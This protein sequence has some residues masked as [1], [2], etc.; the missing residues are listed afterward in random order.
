LYGLALE[1]L[2]LLARAQTR[3]LQSG[4][5]R[6]Y[7]MVTIATTVGLVGYTLAGSGQLNHVARKPSDAKFY[8][9]VVAV[10]ILFA[11]VVVTRAQSRLAAVAALGVVGYGVA[12]IFI[13]FSAP[14]LAM[15]QFTI[16]TLTVVLFVLVIYKLPR[17]VIYSRISHRLRDALVALAAGGMMTV[18]ILIVTAAPSP[19]RL[20]SYFAENSLLLAKGR[21]VVNVILVDFRGLDT[22]GEITVLAIAAIGV[23]ALLKLRLEKDDN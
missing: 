4:Y 14:D 11:A 2:D 3:L 12:L 16:E 13:F 7:L 9:I 19:S 18:L 10:L 23:Y 6:F 20:T 1:G 5:L 8:E 15:T 17:F 21:N 22:F